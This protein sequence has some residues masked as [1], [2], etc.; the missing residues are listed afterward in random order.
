MDPSFF[1]KKATTA[2]MIGSSVREFLPT[3]LAAANFFS[4]CDEECLISKAGD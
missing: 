3:C 2:L 4:F 1:N